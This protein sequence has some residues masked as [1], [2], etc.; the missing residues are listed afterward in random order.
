MSF[1]VIVYGY[2]NEMTIIHICLYVTLYQIYL[3]RLYW[4]W[5]EIHI[6][7][8]IAAWITGQMLTKFPIF[9]DLQQKKHTLE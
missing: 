5:I 8:K 7:N 1:Y 9:G 2:E 4:P 3:M 6:R